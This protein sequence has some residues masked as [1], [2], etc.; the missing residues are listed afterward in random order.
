MKLFIIG[1]CIVSLLLVGSTAYADWS[2]GPHNAGSKKVIAQTG[3]ATTIMLYNPDLEQDYFNILGNTFAI[4][5]YTET[6]YKKT[7]DEEEFTIIGVR[8]ISNIMYDYDGLVVDYDIEQNGDW[9]A[10]RTWHSSVPKSIE[11]SC[12]ILTP[13]FIPE[14]AIG[15]F[16]LVYAG[17]SAM[18]GIVID[19]EGID[20]PLN[21]NVG[22]KKIVKREITNVVISVTNIGCEPDLRLPPLGVIGKIE[23]G[24][25]NQVVLQKLDEIQG[26]VRKN[27][28]YITQNRNLLNRANRYIRL[29]YRYIR[30][31][32][33]YQVRVYR[34]VIKR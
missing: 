5:A 15:A 24:A 10:F 12:L 17:Q 29:I 1:L 9:G 19:T 13:R 18:L 32:Y 21:Y 8:N 34:A 16:N 27:N 30:R 20:L 26:V 14:G 3:K 22:P 31:I 7:S 23:M 2:W 33:R 28:E 6:L 4:I 11:G 25:D